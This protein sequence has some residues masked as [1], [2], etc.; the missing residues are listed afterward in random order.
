[1]LIVIVLLLILFVGLGVI[2]ALL[3]GLAW[4][5]V[6]GLVGGC[7]TGAYLLVTRTRS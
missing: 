3:K 1:M 5:L 4:L 6:V 7:I 2:G